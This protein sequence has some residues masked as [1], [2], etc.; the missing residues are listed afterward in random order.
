MKTG[1][2]R[3]ATAAALAVLLA[4]NAVPVYA[5]TTTVEPL[6]PEPVL[7]VRSFKTNPSSLSVGGRFKLE[8]LLDDVVD[9]DADNVVVTVGASTASGS[10]SSATSSTASGQV[11]EVVVLGTNT[12][13]V[14]T[15]VGKATNKSVTFDLMS[16]PKGYPGPFSLPVTVEM[17]NPNGGRITSV[18]S[19]GLMFTRTLVFDVGALTY[20]REATAG[21]PFD[22]SV[23]V[24]NTNDFAING[25]ALSFD[26][27]GTTWTSKETTVGVLE[28]GAESKLVAT[29]VAQSP[30]KL[31]VTMT[32]SYKDD[33]NA[34]KQIR[35]QIAI[36]IVPKP[37]E[38]IPPPPPG[39][40][41]LLFLKALLGLGG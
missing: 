25:V 13:F 38:V 30:G 19:V 7:V 14:G 36:T 4:L 33:Y 26:A 39:L 10:A 27:S 40:Q 37:A 34:T 31:D 9:V 41:L 21:A 8:L 20:P 15:I 29:G 22:L 17:D 2:R 3:V 11:P 28:P 12:R 32:I 18:Q 1:W 6:K 35:R 24:R 16:N 5:D 23:S